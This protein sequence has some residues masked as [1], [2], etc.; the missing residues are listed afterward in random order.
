L[1]KE[2]KKIILTFSMISILG[3][4]SLGQ[5]AKT[6]AQI[7]TVRSQVND[8]RSLRSARNIRNTPVV[9]EDAVT[10]TFDDPA[11]VKDF[12]VTAGKFEISDGALKAVEGR[13]N[14]TCFLTKNTFGNYVRIEM[15]VTSFAN[16]VGRIGDITFFLNTVP[17]SLY[18][19]FF[20]KGYSLT[21]GSYGNNC[22]TFYRLGVAMANTEYSPLVSGK[23]N[24][25]VLEFINGQIR[26]W[27]NGQIILEGWDD[28]PLQMDP[29]L[30][31]GVRSYATLMVIDRITIS[32]G[33]PQQK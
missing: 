25:A 32:R 11:Q 15:E 17:D 2:M 16:E 12:V 22:T 31:I 20:T 14:R 13:S 28:D 26:Y 29:N 3:T 5:Q 18:A 10:Y 9:W 23:K 7:D 30:W 19:V 1:E 24:L 33:K 4:V 27:L 21:T 8:V 6:F